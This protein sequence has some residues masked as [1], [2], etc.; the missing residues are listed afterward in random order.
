[1]NDRRTGKFESVARK[2][3]LSITVILENVHD[4]LNIGAI[5]RTS[6][7]IGIRKIY[8]IN[9]SSDKK[10]NDLVL[11]KRSSMGTRKWIDVEYYKDL[12]S[13]VSAVRQKYDKIIGT[14]M[15]GEAV[16]YF[17]KD[18][19]GS[20]AIMLGNE[21]EGLS[22]KAMAH[23]DSLIY[24]PQI[25]MAESLN[26]SAATAIILYEAFRQRHLAGK[27]SHTPD[28]D[29][30]QSKELLSKFHDNVYDRTRN[31]KKFRLKP[32]DKT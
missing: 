6:D 22:E 5:L 15:S 14:A 28:I 29:E 30:T 23:C 27:Y 7:S 9:T 17:D 26:V 8:V 24:I 31:E 12:D 3:Q 32:I 25:G 18:Y 20:V 1:M 4:S 21:H 16:S 19:T 11:G 2:S 13:C 10:Y